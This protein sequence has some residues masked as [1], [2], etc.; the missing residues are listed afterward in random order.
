[1]K[2]ILI[3][4]VKKLGKKGEIIEVSNGYAWNYL[5][6]KGL[7]TEATDSKLKENEE[8][9][10]RQEKQQ[11]KQKNQAVALKEKINGVRIKIKAHTGG[12]DKL[13]GAVTP[14]EIAEALQEQYGVKID[15]K[16]IDISEPIKH[17]GEYPVKLKIYPSVQAEIMVLVEAD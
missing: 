17:L 14:K 5:I 16:K 13:F 1:M 11:Q 8:Q 9:R 7:A 6:P 12:G 3:Q 10:T 4:E 2:V 15:K